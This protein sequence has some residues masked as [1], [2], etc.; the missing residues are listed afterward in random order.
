MHPDILIFF[1][2]NDLEDAERLEKYIP[3]K[4]LWIKDNPVLSTQERLFQV[5]QVS[6]QNPG[7]TYLGNLWGTYQS[8][9]LMWPNKHE[10]QRDICPV[11]PFTLMCW[12]FTNRFPLSQKGDKRTCQMLDYVVDKTGRNWEGTEMV[13]ANVLN[14]LYSTYSM[15]ADGDNIE[16]NWCWYPV[17]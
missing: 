9:V 13:S 4:Y 16:L 14:Q 3:I 17:W 11:A 6:K 8:L 12:P 7:S 10:I 1:K 15:P 5:I 2:G